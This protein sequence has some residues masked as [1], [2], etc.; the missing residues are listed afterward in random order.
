MF[1]VVIS[2]ILLALTVVCA[3]LIVAD[4]STAAESVLEFDL[5]GDVVFG[6]N[7]TLAASFAILAGLLAHLISQVK[8]SEQIIL[9]FFFYGWRNS[10]F[11]DSAVYPSVCFEGLE[12]GQGS[13]PF[14]LYWKWVGHKW[15]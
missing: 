11:G 10:L 9:G 2:I 5:A 15:T 12:T 8:L 6:L 7:F 1:R 4:H 14:P 3:G 13:R